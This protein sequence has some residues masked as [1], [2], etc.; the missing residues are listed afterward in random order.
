MP[1]E[2]NDPPGQPQDAACTDASGCG[3]AS[4]SC[5][6][7]PILGGWCGE[8]QVDADCQG[9]G[10]TIPN[11]IASVGAV[12]NKGQPGD[13]CQ[14]DAVCADPKFSA[15]GTVLKVEGIIT[16]STCGMCTTNAD[17]PN[18]APNCSPAY[19]VAAF[20]GMFECVPNASVPN[21]EGCN[22]QL[23]GDQ[24]VG[25]QACKSGFCGEANVMGLLKMGVCGEC[26]ANADCGPGESCNDPLV[27][28][29]SNEIV[30]ASCI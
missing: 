13:G 20:S 9:G 27:D 1:V 25:N 19:D 3:C 14:S 7:I 8:C 5:F 15:C 23:Q 11:P 12:C 17:C 6:V 22:L 4:G 2:C 10:C 24:P 18:N 29:N 30:G 16:V 26:N 21:N 28:L